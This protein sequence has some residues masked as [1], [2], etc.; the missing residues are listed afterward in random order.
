MLLAHKILLI[1]IKKIIT[2]QTLPP[3]ILYHQYMPQCR[4]Q[5]Y[6]LLLLLVWGFLGG[7][8]GG[9]C[10]EEEGAFEGV[11]GW[12]LEDLWY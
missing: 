5:S 2:T 1:L 6:I 10:W 11:G 7:G 8:L 3:L 9:V 4:Y 12:G